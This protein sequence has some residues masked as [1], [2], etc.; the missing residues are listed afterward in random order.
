MASEPNADR[1]KGPATTPARKRPSALG[2]RGPHTRRKNPGKRARKGGS[3][4]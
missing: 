2:V 3:S 4:R 1:P